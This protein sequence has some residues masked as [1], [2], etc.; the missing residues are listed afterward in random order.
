MNME[1]EMRPDAYE[2]RRLDERDVDAMRRKI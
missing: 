2:V 1:I